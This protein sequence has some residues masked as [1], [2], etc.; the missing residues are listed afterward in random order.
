MNVRRKQRGEKNETG[1]ERLIILERK[2][3]VYLRKKASEN[4]REKDRKRMRV[5][6]RLKSKRKYM[7]MGERTRC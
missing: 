1:K 2:V 5:Q 4:W 6:E 7:E 3:E